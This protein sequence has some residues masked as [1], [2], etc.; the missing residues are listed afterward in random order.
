M[1]IR[2][3]SQ[4]VEDLFPDAPPGKLE[5]ENATAEVRRVVKRLKVNLIPHLE[6]AT[7]MGVIPGPDDIY[8]V[9]QAL[10]AEA[11]GLNPVPHLECPDEIRRYFRRTMFDE[12]VGEPSNVL[13]TTQINPDVVRYE[14][15]PAD[16]WKKCLKTLLSELDQG[17]GGTL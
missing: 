12:L 9:I 13:Y 2:S 1:K 15:M 10:L 4:I 5:V 6:G 16:F 11:D 14:A 8:A 17:M 3:A 7:R